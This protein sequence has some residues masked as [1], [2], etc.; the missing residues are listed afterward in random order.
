MNN[1]R[2]GI[3]LGI[4]LLGFSWASWGQEKT[5]FKTLEGIRHAINPVM[6]LNGIVR[7]E[8]E[9]TL[10]INPY[11]R[12]EVEMDHFSFKRRYDGSVILYGGTGFYR[13][14]S[15]GEYLGSYNKKGQ[16]P[17]EFSEWNPIVPFFLA[18]QIWVVN[19]MKLVEFDKDGRFLHERKLKDQPAIF[20]D[21]SHFLTERSEF[22]KNGSDQTK[23]LTLVRLGKESLS[24]VRE[25]D[26]LSGTGIG[27][28]RNKNGKGGLVDPWGTPN[29]C[30]AY[31][32][33]ARRIYVAINT[34][35]KIQV[36]N[37]KGQTITVIE[38]AHANVKI[39]R[40][41]VETILGSMVTK[42]PFKWMLDAY[43]DRLVAMNDIQ[44]LPNSYLLVRRICGPKETEVDVFDGEGRYVY[45]LKSPQ[46]T[47]FDRVT[48]H[49]RGY[50]T[51]ET[52]GDFT[53]YVD[54]RIKNLPEVFGK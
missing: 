48:F 49:D 53:V 19:G 20:I 4:F 25:T 11:D 38:K 8:V 9:K 7:L 28:I 24:D 13:F 34:E 43:P 35:Y 45:A 27:S 16:G 23:T 54:Y 50:S 15:K 44:P 42:E 29:I 30:Y 2:K 46:G 12:P 39:S 52:K 47:S 22:N 3:A 51:I 14:G 37:L 6:P 21:E 32:S 26:I 5:E 41:D 40:K 33:E 18:G 10:L 36:K 1:T 31:G 17:G